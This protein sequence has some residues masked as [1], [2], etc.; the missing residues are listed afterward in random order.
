MESMA[1]PKKLPSEGLCKLYEDLAQGAVGLIMTSAVRADRHWDHASD[2]QNMCL[3]RDDQIPAFAQ[4]VDR[5]HAFESKVGLQ[6]GSFYRFKGDFVLPSMLT[7]DHSFKPAPRE[8]ETAEIKRIIKTYGKAGERAWKA[9]FDAIQ[10][11]AAHGFPLSKFLS[12]LF[13]QRQDDYG[14]SPK[15]RARI[16]IE[17]V[18]EIKKR[19][20]QDYPVFIKMNVSDFCDGGMTLDDAIVIAKILSRNGI[21][22]IETSGGTAGSDINQ[23]GPTDPAKW[24][25]GYFI[26]YAAAIKAE[27]QVPTILV[28]GL[29]N[30]TMMDD[31]LRDGKAD[32]VAMSRPFIME[33]RIVKR[34]ME[35]N[36]EPSGCISCDG[37]IEVFLSG[38]PV[39]CVQE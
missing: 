23:S 37:C 25:E 4:L 12:P 38:E 26:N 15:N 32:L 21:S 36:H 20:D 1:T 35:G 33:P 19:I 8:L 30:P 16:I 11:N 28:G 22:A 29:R 10:L 17:I 39:H 5:V 18:A 13:N 9:G 24:T 27:A 6:L 3:D 2:S 34:W 7:Q 14:G 31:V